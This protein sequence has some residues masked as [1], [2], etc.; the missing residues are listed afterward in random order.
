M[1]KSALLGL[2][3]ALTTSCSSLTSRQNTL[4]QEKPA[5]SL[6]EL[7]DA[8]VYEKDLA[9]QVYIPSSKKLWDYQ[10]YREE[11]FGYVKEFFKNYAVNCSI[12]CPD[13]KE[14][15]SFNARNEFRVEIFDSDEALIKRYFE[16]LPQTDEGEINKK[17]KILKAVKGHAITQKG[18]VLINGGVE[19]F[20]G[21][22]R[23]EI[24]KQFL[25]EYEGVTRKEYLLRQNAANICHEVLHCLGL[26]H[27]QTFIPDVT[28]IYAEGIPNIMSYQPPKFTKKNKTGYNL[29]DFQIRVMHSYLSGNNS[30]KRFLASGKNLD[31]LATNIA[32]DNNLVL[33]NP[34]III[35]P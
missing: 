6:E 27:P 8:E 25:E 14:I 33:T 26:F 28:N 17:I 1:K 35:Q 34:V 7:C 15:S 5:Y 2:V 20:R 29:N 9:L 19:E 31:L 23:E 12:T 10:D 22:K 24:E 18:I 16:L 30:Y 21:M 3:L 11:L 13:A 4:K 32:R